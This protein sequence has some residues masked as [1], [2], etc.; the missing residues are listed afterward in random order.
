MVK[1]NGRPQC[2][3]SAGDIGG[4]RRHTLEGSAVRH[5]RRRAFFRMLQRLSG[6]A[7]GLF[8]GVQNLTRDTPNS[9]QTSTPDNS[10]NDIPP[11]SDAGFYTA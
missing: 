8:E 5:I 1:L 11:L 10:Q 7:K 6:A 3:A 2:H 9:A 4:V